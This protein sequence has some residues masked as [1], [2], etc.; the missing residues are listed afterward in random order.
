MGGVRLLADDE[1]ALGIDK[2][3]TGLAALD[4]NVTDRKAVDRRLPPSPSSSSSPATPPHAYPKAADA[5]SARTPAPNK[6]PLRTPARKSSRRKSGVTSYKEPA[7]NTKL[8]QGD[9]FFTR[10]TPR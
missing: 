6:T 5:S 7:L 9:E 1:L 2:V 10:L 3:R 4:I 8:R